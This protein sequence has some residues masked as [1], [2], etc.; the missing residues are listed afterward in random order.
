MQIIK[1]LT[2]IPGVGKSIAKDLY[3]LVRHI[4]DLKGEDPQYFTT[5]KTNLQVPFRKCELSTKHAF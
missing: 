5:T 2:I 1:A 4:D 3:N